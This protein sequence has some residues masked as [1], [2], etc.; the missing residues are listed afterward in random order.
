LSALRDWGLDDAGHHQLVRGLGGDAF[1]NVA[2]D[3]TIEAGVD[4][5]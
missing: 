4:V 2:Q 1:V 3:G 5:F